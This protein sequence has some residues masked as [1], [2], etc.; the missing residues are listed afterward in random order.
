MKMTPGH[1]FFLLN[2]QIMKTRRHS[3][4]KKRGGGYG[5][6]GS[7]LDGSSSN[8]ANVKWDSDTGKDCGA[9]TDR[10]GNGFVGGKRRRHR[11]GQV[12][13]STEEKPPAPPTLSPD[14]QRTLKSIATSGGRRRRG[15]KSR[16]TRRKYKGGGDLAQN[17]P[18]ANYS[19]QGDGT[20]GL[21][22]YA[23]DTY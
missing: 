9:G 12:D 6:G 13:D 7:I 19:F 8:S 22:D 23:R 16:R 1:L 2:L 3:L 5:F 4:S 14:V 18:R 17:V 20:K 10:G 11:G 15:G 21:V